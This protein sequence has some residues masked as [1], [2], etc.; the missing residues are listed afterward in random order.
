MIV[1]VDQRRLQ[2]CRKIKRD[3]AE[4]QVSL[5]RVGELCFH[6]YACSALLGDRGEAVVGDRDDVGRIEKL[7]VAQRC[8]DAC[9]IVVGVPDRGERCRA[10]DAGHE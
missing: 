1:L 8:V 6:G 9:Q 10:V 2:R 5:W 7:K 4:R 3:E